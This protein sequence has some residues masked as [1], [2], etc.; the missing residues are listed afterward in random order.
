MKHAG[1]TL[2]EMVVVVAIVAMVAALATV[3]FSSVSAR[4]SLDKGT[5]AVVA[6]LAQARSLTVSAKNAATYG[7]HLQA[8]GPVLFVGT[9]YNSSDPSNVPSLLDPRL[10]IASTSLVGGGQDIVFNKLTGSTTQSGTFRV[11]I[12]ATPALYHVITVYSTGLAEAQ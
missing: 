12:T 3:S 10:S 11:Q 6:L 5:D 7:V 1:F 2:I 4:Q 9:S 8:S